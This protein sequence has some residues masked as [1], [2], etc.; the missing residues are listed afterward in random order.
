MR[1]IY[2]FNIT[3]MT[4]K[5]QHF[6]EDKRDRVIIHVKAKNISNFT[7]LFLITKIVFHCQVSRGREIQ[8]SHFSE[9]GYLPDECS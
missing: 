3:C 5:S 6:Y 8:G 2:T 9:R 1:N 7:Y 4:Q